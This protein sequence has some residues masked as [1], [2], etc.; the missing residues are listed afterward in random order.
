MEEI[1]QK[2]ICLSNVAPPTIHTN[3][4]R[5]NNANALDELKSVNIQKRQHPNQ[6]TYNER[7]RRGT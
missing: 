2:A 4:T 1:Q 6:N 7:Y 5:K 3:D